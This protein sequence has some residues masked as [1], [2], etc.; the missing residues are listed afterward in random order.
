VLSDP[1]FYLLLGVVYG[2]LG[3]LG[4][5]PGPKQPR[6]LKDMVWHPIRYRIR[7]ADLKGTYVSQLALAAPY[8]YLIGL[9]SAVIGIL[10]TIYRLMGEATDRLF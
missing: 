6:P 2:S 8:M 5:S 1:V 10:L 7:P 9:A 4:L 3:L